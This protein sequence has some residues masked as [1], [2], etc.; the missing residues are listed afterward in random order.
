V[1]AVARK[2]HDLGQLLTK[3]LLKWSGVVVVLFW[4]AAPGSGTITWSRIPN[5]DHLTNIRRENL[6]TY[7]TMGM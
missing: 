5:E 4:I 7:D 1:T 2:L 6:E 3:I